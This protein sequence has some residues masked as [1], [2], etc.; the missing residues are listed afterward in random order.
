MKLEM[1]LE[2]K[3]MAHHTVMVR[4]IKIPL[5]TFHKAGLAAA[6]AAIIPLCKERGCQVVAFLDSMALP[7]DLHSLCSSA[8]RQAFDRLVQEYIVD[9]AYRE[10]FPQLDETIQDLGLSTELDNTLRNLCYEQAEDKV[11][12]AVH[13]RIGELYDNLSFSMQARLPVPMTI[14]SGHGRKSHVGTK[15]VACG[16]ELEE[17]NKAMRLVQVVTIAEEW[18]RVHDAA[19]ED[20]FGWDSKEGGWRKEKQKRRKASPPVNPASAVFWANAVVSADVVQQLRSIADCEQLSAQEGSAQLFESSG[21]LWKDVNP[22]AIIKSYVD[23]AIRQSEDRGPSQG[24]APVASFHEA[25]FKVALDTISAKLPPVNESTND[26]SQVEDATV[27]ATAI[28]QGCADTLRLFDKPTV[29]QRTGVTMPSHTVG[30][31]RRALSRI[32][33]EVVMLQVTAD[34]FPVL[35][36]I[37]IDLGVEK[38]LPPRV[39]ADAKACMY[40]L[41][42]EVVRRH[43]NDQVLAGFVEVKEA[44]KPPEGGVIEAPVNGF[45]IRKYK[46]EDAYGF[47]LGSGGLQKYR[48]EQPFSGGV[49]EY[50]RA[51]FNEATLKKIDAAAESIQSFLQDYQE[52]ALKQKENWIDGEGKEQLAACKGRPKLLKQVVVPCHEWNKAAMLLVCQGDLKAKAESMQG[53]AAIK[54]A[55]VLEEPEALHSSDV[56]RYFDRVCQEVVV[57]PCQGKLFPQLDGSVTK[58]AEKHPQIRPIE[59]S[60]RRKVEDTA[61]GTVRKMVHARVL[62]TYKDVVKALVVDGT[63]VANEAGEEQAEDEYGVLLSEG[64]WRPSNE[65]NNIDNL[66]A[67][68]QQ[69]AE[70]I[71]DASVLSMLDSRVK[72]TVDVYLTLYTTN[73]KDTLAKK[74]KQKPEGGEMLYP[75]VELHRAS[76]KNTIRKLQPKM[77][78]HGGESA[79]RAARVR[80]DSAQS[81]T[82][83]R[84]ELSQCLQQF[85]MDTIESE[86]FPHMDELIA[87]KKLPKKGA[88]KRLRGETKDACYH[89][90]D[91]YVRK[92]IH[93]CVVSAYD[94]VETAY[95]SWGK[96]HLPDLDEEVE[97]AEPQDEGAWGMLVSEGGYVAFKQ[98]ELLGKVALVASANAKHRGS[99]FRKSEQ[100]NPDAEQADPEPEPSADLDLS[101]RV[102]GGNII[103]VASAQN[104]LKMSIQQNVTKHINAM[105]AAGALDE[106]EQSPDR[107]SPTPPTVRPSLCELVADAADFEAVLKSRGLKWHPNPPSWAEWFNGEDYFEERPSF[108]PCNRPRRSSHCQPPLPL[109]LVRRV[110]GGAVFEVEENPLANQMSIDLEATNEVEDT[111]KPGLEIAADSAE[112]EAELSF[113][114]KKKEE[115]LMHQA[116]D[117]EEEVDVPW[118]PVEYTEDEQRIM[119]SDIEIDE[120]LL[121]QQAKISTTVKK[122]AMVAKIVLEKV[123]HEDEDESTVDHFQDMDSGEA[124]AFFRETVED[125]AWA[126]VVIDLEPSV[127]AAMDIHD[128]DK[129][130]RYK[131]LKGSYIWQPRHD[132]D[133]PS[134]YSANAALSLAGSSLWTIFVDKCC[135]LL[136]YLGVHVQWF[137]RS[138]CANSCWKRQTQ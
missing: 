55:M 82:D 6:L 9:K 7:T 19:T 90:A 138:R 110:Q 32:L 114:D 96:E 73:S 86:V 48:K 27:G 41:A 121:K 133:Y 78:K 10:I 79:A 107:L 136:P 49:D 105:L 53:N 71:V 29:D 135:S 62:D 28:I 36:T 16:V 50:V 15:R 24:A 13:D 56:R 20:D 102:Q 25:G 64:G 100:T 33:G 1:A 75:R 83:L 23:T 14:R 122:F 101:E 2:A 111:E 81:R 26:E 80:L 131:P 8:M 17:G 108:L 57:Q 134:K 31:R 60:V 30:E 43:I 44:V 116:E 115:W 35:D 132:G 130:L 125:L 123:E 87:A 97:L 74:W 120:V 94:S 69:H 61:E 113:L 40:R 34:V 129:C 3:V 47:D 92:A 22:R 21:T 127:R 72:A 39:I 84:R 37:V 106:I 54:A 4:N 124:Q 109:D 117:A 65:A 46:G 68:A 42:E 91:D 77:A 76:L 5:Y 118:D 98:R 112:L 95:D 89:H 59:E 11:R 18:T 93:E 137:C 38:A 45:E 103:R 70:E 126:Q 88:M 119:Q 12:I 63:A 85:I 104:N 52:A 66:K 51:V 128:A 58:L 99:L 67:T